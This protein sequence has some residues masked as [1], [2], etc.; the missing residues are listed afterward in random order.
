MFHKNSLYFLGLIFSI[1]LIPLSSQFSYGE[2]DTISVDSFDV[3][4]NIENGNIES[5]FLDP[6]FNTLYS[7]ASKSAPLNCFINFVV[8]YLKEICILREVF[9][10]KGG[11]SMKCCQCVF[12]HWRIL[13][14]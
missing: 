14:K 11:K 4:Y 6:D 2:I 12:D 1:L 10:Q 3:D 9:L 7:T 5:I 13:A 8:V